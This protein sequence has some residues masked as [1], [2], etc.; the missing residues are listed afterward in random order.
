[1]PIEINAK[2]QSR[3]VL[4]DHAVDSSI[5]LRGCLKILSI[6]VAAEVT[7]LI[8]TRNTE[9]GTQIDQ[10]LVTSAATI[11]SDTPRSCGLKLFEV[12]DR[13]FFRRDFLEG[14]RPLQLT[15]TGR[16]TG[17]IVENVS[18]RIFMSLLFLVCYVL[19]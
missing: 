18:F 7:R 3:K 5:P 12:H 19:E 11:F 13:G 15:V 9:L 1:M 14:W 16:T 17:T 10:S 4:R 2:A 6:L 8:S